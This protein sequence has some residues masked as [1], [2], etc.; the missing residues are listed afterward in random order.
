MASSKGAFKI[1][2]LPTRAKT[3]RAAA[4]AFKKLHLSMMSGIVFYCWKSILTTVHTHAGKLCRRAA[5]ERSC[6]FAGAQ[7]VPSCSISPGRWA[8][9]VAC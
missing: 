1:H 4:R 5:E 9:H 8:H 2:R 3:Y 7:A 6:L